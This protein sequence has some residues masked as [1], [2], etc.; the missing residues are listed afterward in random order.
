MIKHSFLIICIIS[1][2]IILTACSSKSTYYGDTWSVD[3]S[4]SYTDLE[5]R[6][7]ELEDD[8]E[9][10]EDENFGLKEDIEYYK[11]FLRGVYYKSLEDNYLHKLDC[12][13]IQD[14]KF[15]AVNEIDIDNY[16]KCPNCFG[17]DE[18]Y[19]D[20]IDTPCYY[21]SDEEKTM[22]SIIKNDLMAFYSTRGDDDEAE[23]LIFVQPNDN[24]YHKLICEKLID[25]NAWTRITASNRGYEKCPI[26][27]GN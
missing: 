12:Y 23:E 24:Y 21:T 6:I 19:Y 10:L 17:D 16:E 8:I 26:C 3:T 20:C 18:Y 27:F 2:C 5:D 7:D 4:P 14:D 25:P 9:E 13:N 11:R 1:V 22:H 15:L